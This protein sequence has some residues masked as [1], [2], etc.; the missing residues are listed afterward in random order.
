[1][2]V[3]HGEE[4]GLGHRAAHVVQERAVGVHA[5]ANEVEVFLHLGDEGALGHARC[6]RLAIE[7]GDVF[8]HVGEGDGRDGLA[9][10]SFSA[11]PENPRIADGVAADHHAGRTG[12]GE[13]HSGAVGRS[14]V[15][16]GQH[17]TADAARRGGDEVVVHVAAIAL[18]DRAAMH[19]EQVDGMLVHQTEEAFE[20][21]RRVEAEAHLHGEETW[22]GAAQCSEEFVHFG[23]IAQEAT[24]DVL[25][26][27]LRGG[28][29]QVEVNAGNRILQEFLH[30]AYH[31]GHVLPDELGEDRPAGPVLG[32]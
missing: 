10:E 17:G 2:A 18:L 11:L 27:D 19:A 21:V 30:G 4:F 22:H 6:L 25:L 29:T 9:G 16:V 7:P 28:A 20:V 32:E 8:A 31:V 24:P 5:L 13:H 1:M 14:N 15:A 23:R 3:A 26:V 12:R